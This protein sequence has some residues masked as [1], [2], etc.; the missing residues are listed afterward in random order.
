MRHYQEAILVNLLLRD[1]ALVQDCV[2]QALMAYETRLLTGFRACCLPPAS[3]VH[4][5]PNPAISK[6]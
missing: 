1:P 5:N 4:C 6:W 3:I 2:L